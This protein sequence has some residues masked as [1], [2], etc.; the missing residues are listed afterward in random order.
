[1]KWLGPDCEAPQLNGFL[2]SSWNLQALQLVI[3]MTSQFIGAQ[4]FA[5]LCQGI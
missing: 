2:K 5:L 3:G 4:S 1:M